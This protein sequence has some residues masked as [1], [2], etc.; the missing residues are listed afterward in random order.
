[1][2]QDCNQAAGSNPARKNSGSQIAQNRPVTKDLYSQL[3]LCPS[4]RPDGDH[5]RCIRNE[6]HT[7]PHH[8]FVA[9]WADGEN[10]S[11]RRQPS[12]NHFGQQKRASSHI[13][14]ISHGA[15]AA[16]GSLRLVPSAARR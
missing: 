16:I 4:K 7:G 11:R 10:S 15:T 3:Q 8:T 1:L 9:E 13:R 6:K 12:Q 5:G 14:R 2:Q